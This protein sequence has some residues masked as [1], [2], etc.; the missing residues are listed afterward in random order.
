[1]NDVAISIV[2][3]N[4]AE[5]I[6]FLLK[7]IS[8]FQFKPKIIC[9]Y[10]AFSE[11]QHTER[12]KCICRKYQGN[13]LIELHSTGRNVGYGDGHNYNVSY[14]KNFK[15]SDVIVIMNSD[16]SV[17]ESAFWGCVKATSCGTATMLS[18]SNVENVPLYTHFEL[19]GLRQKWRYCDIGTIQTDYLAGS[20]FAVSHADFLSVNGFEGEY[21]IYWEEVD[22]SLRLKDAGVYLQSLTTHTVIRE[23][24]S[25]RTQ[26]NS[27]YY[28]I[29]NSFHF[30]SRIGNIRLHQLIFFLLEN[31]FRYTKWSL[32]Q[33]TMRPIFEYIQGFSHGLI[34]RFGQK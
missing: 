3:Y 19:T 21:F 33:R 28:L 7:K 12:L 2:S 6:S 5:N 25:L 22:F 1:M 17:T 14:L 15:G 30:K 26:Y 29:R 24:N 10:D 20:F 31:F 34:G 8:R 16:V 4:D 13:L 27:I 9:I 11:I 23:A 18:A 32:T